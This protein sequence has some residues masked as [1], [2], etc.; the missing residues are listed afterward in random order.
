MEWNRI[1]ER[2]REKAKGGGELSDIEMAILLLGSIVHM[3]RLEAQHKID[4]RKARIP[5]K[6][7][8]VLVIQ[9]TS[10]GDVVSSI[11]VATSL[12]RRFPSAEI[13]FLTEEPSRE[14]LKDVPDVSN[15]YV[16]PR[17]KLGLDVSGRRR[18]IGEIISD[19]LEFTNGLKKRCFDLVL[20][21]HTTHLSGYLAALIQGKH[22]MG[23]VA[24]STG[25]IT[26][27]GNMWF[28]FKHYIS[29]NNPLKAFSKLSLSELHLRMAEGN[30]K[31][32]SIRICIKEDVVGSCRKRLHALGIR[33]GRPIIGLVPGTNIK[34]KMW[35]PERFSQLSDE[36]IGKFDANIILFGGEG[37]V[38][39]ADQ[40]ARG[41]KGKII[42]LVGKTTL[43]ELYGFFGLLDNLITVDTGPMHLAGAAGTKTIVLCGPTR[44]GP[45]GREGNVILQANLPCSGRSPT[46]SCFSCTSEECM[47]RIEVRDVISALKLQM[48]LIE[49]EDVD[50]RRVNMYLTREVIGGTPLYFFPLKRQGARLQ[51]VMSDL[52]ELAS[53]NLWEGENIDSLPQEVLAPSWEDIKCDLLLYYTQPQITQGAKM[54]IERINELENTI[55]TGIRYLEK[56]LDNKGSQNLRLSF[57]Q[58][59]EKTYKDIGIHFG[60][61][62]F[63]YLGTGR[64]PK[65]FLDLYRAKLRAC[66]F[67]RNFLVAFGPFS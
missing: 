57:N 67:I 1:L 22:T 13:S 48:G 54:A 51:E 17:S 19:V 37:D 36:L 23:L 60:F 18:P 28:L 21:L 66:K 52:I 46:S 47:K 45:E 35:S 50:L 31:Q 30:L 39:L 38:P 27:P 4:F 10:I 16:F 6:A 43:S 41:A 59:N 26:L 56:I 5:E 12:K 58:L 65:E 11:P 64:R 25:H 49:K 63:V 24:D 9:L 44:I 29:T 2:V 15:V 34:S 3:G 55:N 61:L 7:R 14:I 53:L 32:R 42:N 8:K 33:E 20:N 62:D 40:I